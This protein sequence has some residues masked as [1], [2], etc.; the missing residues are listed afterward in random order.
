MKSKHEINIEKLYDFSLII[1]SNCRFHAVVLQIHIFCKNKRL[2][3]YQSMVKI[4]TRVGST[5]LLDI[6][7]YINYEKLFS[8]YCIHY[9]GHNVDA[10]FNM[11]ML[12]TILI[13]K[14][15]K[16]ATLTR[17]ILIHRCWKQQ[18]FGHQTVVTTVVASAQLW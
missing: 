11:I 6:K 12:Y 16:K 1:C 14:I 5:F 10:G 3:N 17:Q 13:F 18:L 15:A 9:C 2:Y 7:P 8:Y 4:L